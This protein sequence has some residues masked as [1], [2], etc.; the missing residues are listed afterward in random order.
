MTRRLS[1]KPLGF[2]LLGCSFRALYLLHFIPW[3][4]SLFPS[5]ASANNLIYLWSFLASELSSW[6]PEASWG[7]QEIGAF[8]PSS[9][10]HSGCLSE[11]LF[12][13]SA[14]LHSRGRRKMKG[15]GQAF[16][17]SSLCENDRNNLRPEV[18]LPE[19]CLFFWQ[20]FYKLTVPMSCTLV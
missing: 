10:F 20:A 14:G 7:Y 6:A 11:C 5:C 19:E 13:T 2:C 16:N 1:P 12:W 9:W 8:L 18:C 3:H 17:F 4:L 15:Q